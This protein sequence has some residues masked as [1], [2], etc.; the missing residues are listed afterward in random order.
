[1]EDACLWIGHGGNLLLL[2][3]L[4]FYH[5]LP[6]YFRHAIGIKLRKDEVRGVRTVELA[7]GEAPL[8]R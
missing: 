4:S 2:L 7:K 8:R 5:I 6:H 1:M 3:V